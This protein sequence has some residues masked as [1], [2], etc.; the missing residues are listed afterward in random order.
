[1]C[2]E[3]RALL[4]RAVSSFH[5]SFH[6]ICLKPGILWQRDDYT[7]LEQRSPLTWLPSFLG[8]HTCELLCVMQTTLM[9]HR[10]VVPFGLI[11]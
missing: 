10:D 7:Q 2:A 6:P 1:M 4:W 8:E 11:L 9:L 5:R 3:L